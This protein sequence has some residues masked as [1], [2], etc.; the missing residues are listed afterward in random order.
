MLTAY[1]KLAE[2]LGEIAALSAELSVQ[3]E[4][5]KA[6]QEELAQARLNRPEGA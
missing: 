2:T 3:K 4:L 6:L 5:V 1:R